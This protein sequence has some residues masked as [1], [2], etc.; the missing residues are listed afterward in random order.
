MSR[1]DVAVFE[2]NISPFKF[3]YLFRKNL[4][5]KS[6]DPSF[7]LRKKYQAEVVELS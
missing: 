6:V 3:R 4:K 2:L 1:L 7:V 5:M